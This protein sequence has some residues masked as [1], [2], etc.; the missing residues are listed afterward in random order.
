MAVSYVM[1]LLGTIGATAA[2]VDFDP[3]YGWTEEQ[4]RIRS[5]GFTKSGKLF[6][7]EYGNKLRWTLPIDGISSA[8]R[9]KIVTWWE[10]MDYIYF[11]P[12]YANANTTRH[13]VYIINEDCPMRSRPGGWRN[14]F[15]GELILYEQ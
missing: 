1:R 3:E 12:D 10:D 14:K 4:N 15:R 6:M 5:Q 11:Y 2:T 9:D 13:Y 8:D 7:Y